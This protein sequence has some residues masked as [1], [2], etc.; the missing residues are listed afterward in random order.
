MCAVEEALANLAEAGVEERGAVFTRREVADF[1]FDLV[2]YTPDRDLAELK[3]L[4]PSFGAG[5]FLLP[6]IERL[7]DSWSIYGGE[8]S[9]LELA[10]CIRAV[11]LHRSTFLTTRAKVVDLLGERG[12]QLN[13]SEQLANDWLVHGDFLLAPL[14]EPFDVI[15]G[16]P[17]YVRQEMIPAALM[18]AY[19]ARYQTIYDRADLYVPFIERALLAIRE[20]GRLGYI[21]ADRWMKNRYGA[22]LRSLISNG[23]HLQAYVDM[24]DTPAFHTEVS[25][26][27]A[28]FVIAR[29]SGQMTRVASRP[30]LDP[31][32]L[33]K[34]AAAMVGSQ[35]DP[36]GIGELHGVV[37]GSQAWVLSA[38]E[39]LPVLRRLEATF[40]LIEEAGCRVGIG[41]ATGAD[42]AFIGNYEQLDVEPDRK[43]PLV[44]TKD[45]QSGSVQWRGLGVINPFAEDG[46]LVAL[47]RYP[48]LQRY[49]EDR[50]DEISGRHVAQK[51]K[52]NWY[53]TIDRIY[54]ELVGKPK[55][56][57][58][59][60]KG[61]AH[62]VFEE[63]R[64]YPHHNLYY[65][66]SECWDLH[67]LQA[68]LMSSVTRLF[69]SSYSTTMRGGYLRFQA[70]Y[71]RKLR[72]P[73]WKDVDP[74]IQSE[75]TLAGSSRDLEACERAVAK[76]YNL[77]SS[78]VSTIQRTRPG[79]A[80]RPS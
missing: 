75:L 73:D 27:P 37:N 79:H 35:N 59:D 22:P 28:I 30:S 70:Q 80:A 61:S 21:C 53:R 13:D 68:V 71:L 9:V 44:M 6:A 11:E 32:N 43:L 15:V 46:K 50:R 26:Y 42:Q 33:K 45:I 63:G 65:I 74:G 77:S 19:R 66:T 72:V 25:A 52:A 31:S 18:A 49:L 24:V 7:M 78:E 48:R 14:D 76:L 20:G 38:D 29:G 5:D 41:V 58:P 47:E 57:I 67:A 56:L 4:E 12:V 17:P 1:I 60:I 23:F 3:L 16:N 64:L 39:Q 8:R 40:P 69:I 2:E 62:I 51:A 10:P 36:S 34:L 55:L 54:P